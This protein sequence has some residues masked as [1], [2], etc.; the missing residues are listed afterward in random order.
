VSAGP[1]PAITEDPVALAC[2]R[3]RDHESEM[4]Q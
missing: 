1:D 3:F 4:Q 2:Q